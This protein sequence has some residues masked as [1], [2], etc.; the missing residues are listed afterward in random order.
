MGKMTC[1]T[2]ERIYPDL[3]P[4]CEGAEAFAWME[5]GAL[6]LEGLKFDGRRNYALSSCLISG[7]NEETI[8]DFCTSFIMIVLEQVSNS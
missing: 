3:K 5:K 7:A 1:P 2:G 8:T 4:L 6:R